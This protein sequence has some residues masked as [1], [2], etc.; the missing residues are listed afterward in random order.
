MRNYACGFLALCLY[1]APA[2]ADPPTIDQLLADSQ[3]QAANKQFDEA[4]K[5]LQQAQ[6]QEPDNLDVRL[7]I[8][9]V[10]GWQGNYVVAENEVGVLSA[11]DPDNVDIRTLSAYLDYYQG[12]NE[13][14]AGKFASVLQTYPAY[15]EAAEG[16]KL[17]QDAEQDEK[18]E[19]A[20]AA[21]LWQFDAGYEHS[22][23]SRQPSPDW[24][25]EF[26]Q[27][28]R[29]FDGGDTAVHARIEYDEEFDTTN[30]YLEIGVDHKFTP[31]I[32]G[33]FYA[34]HTVDASFR[35]AW[36]VEP[37]GNLR[38][39][40]EDDSTPAVW[41]TLDVKEDQ[42]YPASIATVDPG[43]RFEYGEWAFS[44]N[45]VMVHQW[46]TESV[47]GWNARLDGP[48]CENLRFYL[49]Y[50]NAPDTEDAVTAYTASIYGG[51]AYTFDE[52]H[53][54]TLGYTHDDR[55]NSWIRNAANIAF[56]YRL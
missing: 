31:W 13:A 51:F 12:R 26:A 49:G 1:A 14:A 46:G 44:P 6:T 56:T 37:G 50:S 2:L 29:F 34:G 27:V 48:V 54:L 9:R 28:T 19:K 43:V 18:G 40:Q 5:T 22:S 55:Q 42:Y 21:Y 3:A 39:I 8:A 32:N 11:A 15:T 38:I 41:L 16:L 30:A 17:A 33:Y 23:F 7:A 53:I 24:S 4:L 45:L 52:T 10:H 36:R 35:P 25:D 47:F 20:A